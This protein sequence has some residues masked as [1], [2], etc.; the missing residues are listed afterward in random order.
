MYGP[1]NFHSV[2]HLRRGRISRIAVQRLTPELLA[3][4]TDY[5]HPPTEIEIAIT[6][7]DL[8]KPRHQ[9]SVNFFRSGL[10]TEFL[11][12]GLV[13]DQSGKLRFP[14][15]GCVTKGE[16]DEISMFVSFVD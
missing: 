1:T 10:V 3:E 16:I 9:I 2:P 11:L 4:A 13:R 14:E 7:A 15:R 12:R 8:Q 6:E 5:H